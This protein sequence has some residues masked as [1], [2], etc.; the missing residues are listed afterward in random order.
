MSRSKSPVEVAA[1]GVLKS[2][3]GLAVQLQV[4]AYTHVSMIADLL[5]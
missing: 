4:C 1:A 5:R 3:N 2:G